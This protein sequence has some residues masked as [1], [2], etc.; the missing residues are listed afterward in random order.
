ME[1]ELGE[2]WRTVRLVLR[3]APSAQQTVGGKEIGWEWEIGWNLLAA[4]QF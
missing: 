3:T 2:V 4:R 1:R